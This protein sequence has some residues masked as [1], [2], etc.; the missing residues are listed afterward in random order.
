MLAGWKSERLLCLTR[1]QLRTQLIL[2]NKS[3]KLSRLAICWSKKTGPDVFFSGNLNKEMQ[4]VYINPKSKSTYIVTLTVNPRVFTPATH[5]TPWPYM[6]PQLH[7]VQYANEYTELITHCNPQSCTPQKVHML[8]R[9]RNYWGKKQTNNK[10]RI[11][12]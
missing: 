11:I 2:I 3:L 10:T 1:L 5:H 12:Y 6:A 9:S 8:Q 7:Y 4:L